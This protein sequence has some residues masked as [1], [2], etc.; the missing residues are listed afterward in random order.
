MA[1]VENTRTQQQA[2]IQ[3]AQSELD[4][5]QSGLDESIAK[6]QGTLNAS[7]NSREQAVAARQSA[8]ASLNN[9]RATASSSVNTASS[10]VDQ[11]NSSLET[12]R[13]QYASAS[14]AP[15]QAD[16]DAAQAQVDNAR[17][18]LTIAVN[19]LEAAT[20]TAPTGGLVASI[21]ASPGQYVSGG[22]SGGGGSGGSSSN[23]ASTASSGGT[24]SAATTGGFIALTDV[25][26]PQ[27]TAQVSEADIG[28][29]R[30]GQKATFTVSAFPGR[31]FTGAVAR[32]EP[33]GTTSSNVVNYNVVATVDPT[34]VTLLPAMTATVRIITDE[35][36]NVVTVPNSAIAFAASTRAQDS[37]SGA[38]G[39]QNASRGGGSS[40]VLVLRDGQAVPNR[41]QLGASDAR[42]T[43]IISGVQP[44][45]TVV[46]GRGGQTSSQQ[47]TGQSGGGLFPGPG[48]GR[49]GGAN[50]GGGGARPAGGG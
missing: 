36:D 29:V 32:I 9:A 35:H 28:K 38:P 37:S 11:A 18:A 19:N 20:L 2:A 46:T 16:L 5:A 39:D 12:A 41:V 10:Q 15:L 47:P 50:T 34:D 43:E 30:P 6:N 24:T 31:T 4:A 44:G 42:N 8:L 26:S 40:S 22:S 25:S 23:A 49:P 48:G 27:V 33:I 3:K 1:S 14:A 13:A 45:D 17:A 21:N 7:Y